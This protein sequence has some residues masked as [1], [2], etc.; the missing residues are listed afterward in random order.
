MA[1]LFQG[2]IASSRP[3]VAFTPC[4]C[5]FPAFH[6]DRPRPFRA[7]IE[8]ETVAKVREQINSLLVKN[9]LKLGDVFRRLARPARGRADAPTAKYRDPKDP[10]KAWSGRGKRPQWFKAALAAG[11]KPE[12]LLAK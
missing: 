11:A 5:H 4:R 9:N 10:A 12:N 7:E 6:S 8:K 2:R 1:D 3:V